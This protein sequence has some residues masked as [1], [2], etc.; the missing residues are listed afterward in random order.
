MI[1]KCNLSK[2]GGTTDV[3]N[4]IIEQY[5]AENSTIDANTFVE[6]VEHTYNDSTLV[7]TQYSIYP[8]AVRLSDTKVFIAHTSDSTNNYLNGLICDIDGNTITA[9]NST[10]LLSTTGIGSSS[11]VKLSNVGDSSSSVFIAYGDGT[12]SG[13]TLNGVVCSVSGTTITKGTSISISSNAGSVGFMQI[14]PVQ[15]NSV[16]ITHSYGGTSSSTKNRPYGIVCSVSGTTITKGTDTQLLSETT[17]VRPFK[18]S[19]QYFSCSY[20]AIV[21]CVGNNNGNAAFKCSISNRTITKDATSTFDSSLSYVGYSLICPVV[22][23]GQDRYL[24][25]TES[26]SG[27]TVYLTSYSSSTFTQLY[28]AQISNDFYV[29][30]AAACDSHKVVCHA[31]LNDLPYNLKAFVL[32]T[33]DESDSIIVNNMATLSNIAR[34]GSGGIGILVMSLNNDIYKIFMAHSSG[35]PNRYLNGL[36]TSVDANGNISTSNL[37]TIKPSETKIQGLTKTSAT[38]SS[39]GDVWVLDTE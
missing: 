23:N 26:S 10:T 15:S 17:Y 38:T 20:S 14:C 7:D 11:N 25:I 29:M 39:A 9:G 5:L 12:S 2:G 8:K 31:Y 36:L 22:S 28:K 6:F 32:R 3:V 19:S 37:T 16:F 21:G 33:S 24:F 18:N 1:G 13:A 34:S 30:Y 35:E 27:P 4:G